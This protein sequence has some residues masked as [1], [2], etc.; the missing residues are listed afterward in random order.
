MQ[1][2]SN[3]Y[4]NKDKIVR[5]TAGA[6]KTTSLIEDVYQTYK[7]HKSTYGKAP[8]ILLTTFTVKAANELSERLFS[9]AS[10]IDDKDFLSY[11]LS[12]NLEVGTMHS[13]FS[14]ILNQLDQKLPVKKYIS[15]A[16]KLNC[17]KGFFTEAVERKS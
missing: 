3:L 5:A 17:A 6:G 10:K 7:S 11:C 2:N 13:V 1:E 14:S 8:K 4:L 12:S 9:K 15:H 16:Y